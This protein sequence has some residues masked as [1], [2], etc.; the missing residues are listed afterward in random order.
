MFKEYL[1]LKKYYILFYFCVVIFFPFVHFLYGYPMESILYSCIIFTFFFLLWMIIDYFNFKNKINKLDSVLKNLSCHYHDF[2]QKGD[3]QEE[4]Y[5]KIIEHLYDTVNKNMDAMEKSYADQMEYYTMWVHQIKTPISA[6]KLAVQSMEMSYDKAIL[7]QELFKIEQYV[8]MALQYVKINQ[9]ASDLI[10][11][12]YDLH[13]IITASVKKYAS[14]FIY[15]K[16]SIQIDD[17][18]LKVLTDSKWLAFILEQVLSNSVK[19]T[20]EGGVKIYVKNNSLIIEDTGIGIRPEDIERIFEKGYT[21]YNGRLDKRASGIGLYLA[22]KVADSLGIKI[23]IKSK[24]AEG[25]KAVL[26]F[27]DYDLDVFE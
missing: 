14:L 26:T 13:P 21:G 3:L 11:R 16:L 8:E 2:P 23:A 5:Q 17:S 10:L 15:K 24:M 1:E 12:E 18:S 20:Y 6:I 19:Y 4:K 25:T 7:E 22:K 27:K 9:L